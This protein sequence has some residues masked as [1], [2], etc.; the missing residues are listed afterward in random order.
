MSS[1]NSFSGLKLK[2]SFNGISVMKASNS[3]V[4]TPVEVEILESKYISQTDELDIVRDKGK[5]LPQQHKL[6]IGIPSDSQ[7][8][9][10]GSSSQPQSEESPLDMLSDDPC[11]EYPDIE[12]EG[13]HSLERPEVVP[14]EASQPVATIQLMPEGEDP[15]EMDAE[16]PIGPGQLAPEEDVPME[17]P[18]LEEETVATAAGPIAPEVLGDWEDDEHEAVNNSAVPQYS[19]RAPPASLE[20]PTQSPRRA[21]KPLPPAK[22]SIFIPKKTTGKSTVDNAQPRTV[23]EPTSPRNWANT[24]R[25]DV[26]SPRH[27]PTQLDAPQRGCRRNQTTESYRMDKDRTAKHPYSQEA[28]PGGVDKQGDKLIAAIHQCLRVLPFREGEPPPDGWK[29]ILEKVANEFGPF[30]SGKGMIKLDSLRN[31]AELLEA[32]RDFGNRPEDGRWPAEALLLK[33][34]AREIDKVW[35]ERFNNGCLPAAFDALD[36]HTERTLKNSTISISYNP[37]SDDTREQEATAA[38]RA[39]HRRTEF[40]WPF[41]IES[42]SRLKWFVVFA[43]KDRQGAGGKAQVCWH[44][45]TRAATFKFNKGGRRTIRI[46]IRGGD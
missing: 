1:P 17:D 4:L 31:K 9:V 42:T 33:E 35:M 6:C 5:P 11:L 46:W 28:R 41:K 10:E 23:C 12:P 19:A 30:D 14:A 16:E 26:S 21:S 32:V 7:S 15:M 45:L 39:P 13:S 20:S 27:F 24:A 37:K 44:E 25:R 2:Y 8:V 18:R 36:R 40:I 34:K 43:V 3:G 38:K 22:P 29:E